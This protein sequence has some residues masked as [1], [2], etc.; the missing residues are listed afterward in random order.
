M[1][2]ITIVGLTVACAPEMRP[3]QSEDATNEDLGKAVVNAI[4]AE[5]E[6]HVDPSGA[7]TTKA[8]SIVVGVVTPDSSGALGFGSTIL[9]G[10]NKPDGN[11]FYALGSISKVFTGL[12]LAEAV[13]KNELELAQN[14]APLL[15]SDVQ[16]LFD[17]RVHLGDLVSHYAGLLS[18]PENAATIG[19]ENYTLSHLKQCLNLKKCLPTSTP[20]TVYRYSNYGIG[21]LGVA[22][23]NHHGYASFARLVEAKILSVIGMRD[24]GSSGD[25]AF[26]A[27]MSQA[28]SEKRYALGYPVTNERL[29]YAKMGLL[30]AGGGLISTANDM[31]KLL[32]VLTGKQQ[33]SLTPTVKR[34]LTALRDSSAIPDSSAMKSI[35]YA[36]ETHDLKDFSQHCGV[37]LNSTIVHSKAG[38]TP[39]HA[40]FMVFSR[41]QQA[42]V[43]VLANR[44]P[45][46]PAC[47]AHRILS[48]ILDESTH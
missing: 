20:G 35:G 26:L 14:V 41:E 8:P 24:T 2:L 47:I 4:R 5:V 18:M 37:S 15:P 39:S 48:R 3:L 33:S 31:N 32:K 34:A 25:A 13:E 22:M 38:S 42:G 30:D 6:P 36:I 43:I 17:P 40:A 45:F 11:T 12:I 19:A 1:S 16:S 9:N 29:P 46:Q 7:D 44:A 27:P 28:Q 21:I 10:Q 23:Q